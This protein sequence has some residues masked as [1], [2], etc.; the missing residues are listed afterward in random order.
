[1]ILEEYIYDPRRESIYFT[2]SVGMNFVGERTSGKRALR[3][4]KL[5]QGKRQTGEQETIATEKES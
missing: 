4:K 2:I 1:M 3:D 5:S